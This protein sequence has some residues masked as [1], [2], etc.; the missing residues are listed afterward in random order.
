MGRHL[1]GFQGFILNSIKNIALISPEQGT[2][3]TLYC[4]LDPQLANESGCYY[5]NC[6]KKKLMKH[7]YDEE[8]AKRLWNVSCDLLELNQ[9]KS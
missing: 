7:A 6:Q 8:V 9:H 2:Q 5:A 1:T 4:C 3:T